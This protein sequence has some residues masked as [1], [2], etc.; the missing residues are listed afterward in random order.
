[1]I[2]KNMV[3]ASVV[4]LIFLAYWI[5]SSSPNVLLLHLT[6]RLNATG[7]Y[8]NHASA[9]RSAAGLPARATSGRAPAAMNGT[10]STREGC[11]PLASINGLQPSVSSVAGGRRTRFGMSSKIVR[12][13]V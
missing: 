1:V 3:G 13:T 4:G 2:G 6:V 10:R 12:D 11:A 5:L 9:A 8:R 7:N